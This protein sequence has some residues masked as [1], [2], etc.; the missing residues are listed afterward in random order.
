M[1]TAS[2][3]GRAWAAANPGTRRLPPLL[4]LTDPERTPEPWVQAARLPVGAGVIFRAFGRDDAAAVGR[5]LAGACQDNGLTLLV[6]A[7]ATLAARLE[8]HG[9]HLPER[10]LGRAA[11]LRRRNPDWLITGAA[12]SRVALTAAAQVGLDAAV[13]SPVF[14]SHSPSAGDPLGVARF[15]AW[16]AQ[17]EVPVYALGGVTPETAPGLASSGA[18]GL[19]AVGAI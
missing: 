14:A 18:C 2:D 17:A 3:L 4:F 1:A 13:L 12:H 6:G 19:A 15:T 8:A 16:G 11:E 5:R 10:D 9:L 7:D